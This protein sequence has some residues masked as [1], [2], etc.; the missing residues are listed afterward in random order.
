MSGTDEY[1]ENSEDTYFSEVRQARSVY[2]K[3]WSTKVQK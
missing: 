1:E 3:Y 2:L